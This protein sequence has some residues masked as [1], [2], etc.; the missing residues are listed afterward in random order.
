MPWLL[1]FLGGDDFS[2][3]HSAHHHESATAASSSFADISPHHHGLG[4]HVGDDFLFGGSSH[5]HNH[6]EVTNFG[7]GKIKI[8]TIREFIVEVQVDG[9]PNSEVVYPVEMKYAFLNWLND[10]SRIIV[11]FQI[12]WFTFQH[13]FDVFLHDRFEGAKGISPPVKLNVVSN[14][15]T[16]HDHIIHIHQGDVATFS[17]RFDI[18]SW[19]SHC[20]IKYHFKM[21]VGSQWRC[22]H[23]L[24]MHLSS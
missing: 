11:L 15:P 8:P 10:F 18:Q 4:H 9:L 17:V 24:S 5:Y 13:E 19:V 1:P 12:F 20:D 7:S 2:S 14:P 22:R 16:E 6:A 23:K 21:F 3:T